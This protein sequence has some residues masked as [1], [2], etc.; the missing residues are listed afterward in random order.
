MTK[1]EEARKRYDESQAKLKAEIDEL[2]AQSK[3]KWFWAKVWFLMSWPFRW[4]WAECHDW[5][6]LVIFI[7]V[8]VVMSSEVWVCYLLGFIFKDTAF[9]KTMLGVA[10]ACWLFWLGP[11]TPFMPICIGITVGIK[12]LF[13]KIKSKRRKRLDKTCQK[14]QQNIQ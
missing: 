10:S 6:F 4:L 13:D 7:I 5:R 12:A 8:F 1:F 9:G 3:W 14:D 11:G 2:K